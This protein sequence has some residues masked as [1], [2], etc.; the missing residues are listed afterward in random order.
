M[1]VERAA[2]ATMSFC[3]SCCT[4]YRSCCFHRLK[5][6]ERFADIE[7]DVLSKSPNVTKWPLGQGASGKSY[8]MPQEQSEINYALLE[9]WGSQEILSRP[10]G[11]A[12][13]V[14]RTPFNLGTFPTLVFIQL[15]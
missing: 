5:K 11:K 3:C 14:D 10:Q 13:G 1:Q 8:T 2:S 15:C 4:S 12:V 7:Y 6:K 9:R